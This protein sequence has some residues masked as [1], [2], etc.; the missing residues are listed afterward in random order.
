MSP[1]ISVGTT[2]RRLSFTYHDP[3]TPKQASISERRAIFDRFAAFQDG[4]KG[5]LTA[6]VEAPAPLARTGPHGVEFAAC[7]LYFA[8]PLSVQVTAQ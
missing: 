7:N 4:G 5:T 8:F 2:A 1:S 6:R 3:D